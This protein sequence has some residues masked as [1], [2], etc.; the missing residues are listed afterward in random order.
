V[1]VDGS[2]NVFFSDNGNSAIKEWSAVNGH[3][4]L[5]ASAGLNDPEGVAVDATGNVYFADTGTNSIQ[6]LPRVFVDPTPR[7]ESLAAGNDVLPVVLPAVQNLL[8]PFNPISD[9]SWLT[10]SGITNGVVSFSFTA[11]T[12]GSR[13]AHLTLLG[14]SIPITQGAIGTPP[15]LGSVQLLGNGA[16]Q[17]SFTNNPNA[18]FAVLSATNLALPLSNWTV[19]GAASNTSSDVFQFTSQPITNGAPLFFTVRSP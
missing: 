12:G 6:E 14:Q 16:L 4:A 19:V 2:G 10:I 3:V 7:V 13:T 18:V 9:S 1:A 17:F 15:T 8:A 11:D 5:L